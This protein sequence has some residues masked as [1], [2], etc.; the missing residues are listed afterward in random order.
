M[1]LG[2]EH[3]DCQ[4][5][6]VVEFKTVIKG[7]H[8]EKI[9]ESRFEESD[10]FSHDEHSKKKQSMQRPYRLYLLSRLY[11]LDYHSFHQKK[12]ISDISSLDQRL[13]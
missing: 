1:E 13:L 7:D 4:G 3:Q 11:L 9:F 2:K 8:V 12:T 5:D 6:K 10:G